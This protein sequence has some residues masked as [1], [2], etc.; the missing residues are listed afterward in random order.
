MKSREFD[1]P[2][3]YLSCVNP[4]LI[5]A[6]V[7]KWNTYDRVFRFYTIKMCPTIEE[8]EKL[9]DDYLYFKQNVK[10]FEN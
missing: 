6:I 1:I 8:Y 5:G 10:G 9:I 4:E 3:L 2:T 7:H